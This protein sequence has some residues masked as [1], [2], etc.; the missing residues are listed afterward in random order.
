MIRGLLVVGFAVGCGGLEGPGGTA[1]LGLSPESIDFGQAPVN[2]ETTAD[3]TLTNEG[4]G[5][6][7]L[8]SVT[9]T[10]G[11]PDVFTVDRS[12]VDTLLGGESGVITVTIEPEEPG[13]LYNG[14]VQVRTDATGGSRTVTLRGLGGVSVDDADEDGFSPAQGDCDDGNPNVYPG[15]DEICD[16]LDNDC[17]DGVPADEADADDDDWLVCE[18]DCDDD[19]ADVNPGLPERC[20]IGTPKDN[21]CDGVI[22]DTADIDGDGIDICGGDCNDDEIRTFPGNEEVCDGVDNDCDEAID[23]VDRDGDGV[24]F[25]GPFGDCDPDDITAAC[26]CDDNPATGANAFPVVVGPNGDDAGAGTEA[27]P[28]ATLGH[29][30]ANLDTVCRRVVVQPG[31]YAGVGFTWAA[32][33]VTIAGASG[34]ADEVILEAAVD[35]PHAEITGGDVAFANLTL[36]GG[37]VPVDGGAL[38][39]VAAD[40]VL[41]NVI[42]QDNTS[43]ADG[44]AI[45]VTSGSLTVQA[46]CEFLDNEASVDGGAIALTQSDFTDTAV[47]V[48]EGNLAGGQGGAIRAASPTSLVLAR[49]LFEDNTGAGGGAVALTGATP[50]AVVE[51]NRFWRNT[52]TGS[53]GAL[54]VQAF[55]PAA[56]AVNRNRFQD[57]VANG[58][59]GAVVVLGGPAE[60]S[61]FLLHNNSFAGNQAVGFEGAGIAV[62][63]PAAPSALLVTSNML[64]ANDG[65]S[66]VY[67]APGSDAVV[68]YNHAFLTNTGSHFAG[69]VGNGG[70]PLDPTNVVDDPGIV[71]FTDDGNPANDNLVPD[72]GSPLLDSGNPAPEFFDNGVDNDIN[73][74][75]HTGGPSTQ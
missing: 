8:L 19:D 16:G 57:N 32:G 12:G 44:G 20:D 36:T 62:V 1:V 3:L 72:G 66:A 13:R 61:S 23:D 29:A 28:F 40:V 73:D 26:D 60:P 2:L 47:T 10:N 18:G 21:D 38:Q 63:T 43:G 39:V 42:V 75:G 17:A 11:D 9:L 14:T 27:D 70:A 46:G 58:D 53:G 45:A 24:S 33:N 15:A 41:S 31:T 4:G 65:L 30:L 5:T 25:C 7:T 50:N 49:S 48:Y 52:A 56:G 74:R 67:V 55:V 37:S 68:N 54:A 59:G 51:D 34:N 71:S 6:L 22:T 69:A 64:L 35:V